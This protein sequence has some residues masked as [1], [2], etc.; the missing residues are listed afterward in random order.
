MIY[1][2]RFERQGADAQVVPEVS[3]AMHI[4]GASN[5]LLRGAAIIPRVPGLR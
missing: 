3:T 2:P 1:N 5:A 4:A